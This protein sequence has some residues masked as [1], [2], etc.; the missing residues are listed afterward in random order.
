MPVVDEFNKPISYVNIW[1]ENENN[2]TTSEENGE[3]SINCLP[4]K[5][6]IFSALGYEKKTVKVADAEKVILKVNA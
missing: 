5:N 2:S 1:V 3:F 4:N 6:L